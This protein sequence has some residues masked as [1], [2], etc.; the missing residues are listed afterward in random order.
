M[1]LTFSSRLTFTESLTE[2]GDPENSGAGSRNASFRT[3]TKDT[4]VQ[5]TRVIVREM[6]IGSARCAM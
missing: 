2:L 1:P 6:A 5:D 4:L 3:K